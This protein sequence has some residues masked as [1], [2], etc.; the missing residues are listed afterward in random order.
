MPT[1]LVVFF[2]S[3][4]TEH[5]INAP[6]TKGDPFQTEFPESVGCLLKMK[7]GVVRV[8]KNEDALQQDQPLDWPYCDTKTFLSDQNIMYCFIMDGPL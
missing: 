1:F 8:Y 7:E 6:P 5:P 4:S 3:N 2:F